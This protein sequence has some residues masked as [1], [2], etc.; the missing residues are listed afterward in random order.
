MLATSDTYLITTPDLPRMVKQPDGTWKHFLEIKNVPSDVTH[1]ETL[2]ERVVARVDNTYR[3]GFFGK[4]WLLLPLNTEGYHWVFVALLNPTYLGT[5]QEKKFT[6]FC[7]CDNLHSQ[8]TRT[9]D[10]MLL[11][12]RGVLNFLIYANMVYGHPCL[13]TQNVREMLF[14]PNHFA[15][16]S[17]PK[18]DQIAQSDGHNCGIFVWMNMLE[19]SQV[20]CRHYNSITDFDQDES[21]SDGIEFTLKPGDYFKIFKN[22]H[23]SQETEIRSS[24][25]KFRDLPPLI[26][27]AIRNQAQCLCNRIL[28]LQTIDKNV[29]PRFPS[30]VFPS[31]IRQN[32]RKWVWDIEDSNQSGID[33]YMSWMKGDQQ[34]QA[35][36]KLLRCNNPVVAHADMMFE[37]IEEI[38]DEDIR[39]FPKEELVAYSVEQL[40]D[41]GMQEVVVIDNRKAPPPSAPSVAL[42]KKETSPKSV[43]SLARRP[44][45]PTRSVRIRMSAQQQQS[46]EEEKVS[47]FFFI[48]LGGNVSNFYFTL[49]LGNTQ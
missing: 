9:E 23:P 10:M 47:S 43:P 27:D 29:S 41:A 17:I 14:D 46:E 30:T 18:A 42:E 26:F 45:L 4:P 34:N 38:E 2:F 33:D 7:I 15:R 3:R 25:K 13:T 31:Y 6:A 12:N 40:L 19:F 48:F 39:L 11:H 35:L 37:E 21:S 20:H 1:R 22:P 8:R 28:T 44:K 36:G 16:I 32:F 49:L 24:K 5:P